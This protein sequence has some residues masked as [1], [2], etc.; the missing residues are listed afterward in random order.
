MTMLVSDIMKTNVV[1]VS[2]S[3]SLIEAGRIM[4]AHNFRRLPVINEE[5]LVGIITTDD[6]D[7]LGSSQLP[8]YSFNE[9]VYMR[10][11]MT[12][13]DVMRRE[14]VTVS[15]ETTV[16]A[17]VAIAQNK[18][19]GSLLVKKGNKIMGIVTTNDFFLGILNPLLGIGLHGSRI[20]VSDCSGGLDIE[21]I[22]AV[23]NSLKIGIINLFLSEPSSSGKHDLIVHLDTEDAAAALEAIRQIG[24]SAA[25]RDR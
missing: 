18:R 16:E 9:L 10:Q 11:K 22:T 2:G 4:E 6:L 19:V 1:S 8:N 15:P 12:V 21:K 5:E 24:F 13:E 23:I 7:K 20:A 14:V 25:L 17:A 3:T